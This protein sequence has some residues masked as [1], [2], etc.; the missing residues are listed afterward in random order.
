MRN[1]A[2][3]IIAGALLAVLFPFFEFGCS[4]HAGKTPIHERRSRHRKLFL[5]RG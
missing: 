4:F 3:R 1:R 2:A 5:N